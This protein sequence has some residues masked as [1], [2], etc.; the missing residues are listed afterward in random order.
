MNSDTRAKL[1]NWFQNAVIPCGSD[2]AQFRVLG[3]ILHLD[4]LLER[5]LQSPAWV[6]KRFRAHAD[7]DD[8][9]EILWPEKFPES[10]LRQERQ[11]YIDQENASGYSQEYLSHPIAEMDA[12]FRRSDFQALDETAAHIHRLYYGAVDFA[13]STQERAD[14]TAFVIGGVNHQGDLAILD[15]SAQRLDAKDIVEEWFRLDSLYHPEFWVAES[16]VIEKAIG[17]FLYAEM[18]RRGHYMT[19]IPKRPTKDKQSRARSIQARLRA[20]G[21]WFDKTAPWYPGYESEMLSFPRGIHDDMVDATA[22]LGLAL[23][24]LQQSPSDG[25]VAEDEWYSRMHP[26]TREDSGRSSVTGY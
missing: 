7:F 25:E 9:S 3:T 24:E 23:D 6:S 12:Y 11:P 22:W 4:S 19:I 14:R 2:N 15:V 1:R 17:P 16:G 13:V 26:H 8:F 21:V 5:L 18:R 10:R 20:G